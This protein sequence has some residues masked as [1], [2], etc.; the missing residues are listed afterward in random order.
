VG[1]DLEDAATT[2]DS[3]ALTKEMKVNYPIV[4]GNRIGC[5]KWGHPV[6]PTSVFL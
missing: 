5:K 3:V 1:V 4:I 6:W 2:E